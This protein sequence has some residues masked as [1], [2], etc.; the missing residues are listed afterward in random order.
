MVELED[1][2]EGLRKRYDQYFLGLVRTAPLEEHQRVRSALLRMRGA[3]PRSA[4]VRFR[5]QAVHNR[6]LSYERM[7]GRTVRQMEEGTYRRDL[8]K[9]RMRR[10][11]M[12]PPAEEESPRAGGAEAKATRIAPR[13]PGAGGESRRAAA[14]LSEQRMRTI[15]DAYVGA[16]I[17]CSEDTK[18]LTYDVLASRIRQQVPKILEKH[19]ATSVDFK[20][21]IKD[22]K[23][24]LR[25]IPK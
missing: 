25:A 24:M 21:V 10:Q 5:L 22:G 6:F 4:P 23:A 2:T 12:E 19:N 11:E 16:K 3:A 15:F 18:G 9:A 20:V 1:A 17:R 7:W 8:M 13:H 14:D